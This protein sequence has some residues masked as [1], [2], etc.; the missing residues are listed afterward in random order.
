MVDIEPWYHQ[1]YDNTAFW[2]ACGFAKRLSYSLVHQRLTELEP[3]APAFDEL[4]DY[5]IWRAAA[6]DPNVGAWL[7]ID[8]TEAE[9]HAAPRH[10]CRPGEDCPDDGTPRRLQRL[11]SHGA[12][13]LRHKQALEPVDTTARERSLDDTT[14]DD[15][16]DELGRDEERRG[17]PTASPCAPNASAPHGNNCGSLPPPSSNGSASAGSARVAATKSHSSA[18]PNGALIR[19]YELDKH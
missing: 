13:T 14:L 17:A 4:A 7:Y 16:I 3:F 9:T 10:D 15:A 12:R 8:G 18:P 19:P 1:R 5:L 11:D 6:K 2:R